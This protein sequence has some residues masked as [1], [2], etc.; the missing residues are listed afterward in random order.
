MALQED[1]DAVVRL[2][3]KDVGSPSKEI[4]AVWGK[5]LIS[6]S[7][8]PYNT[9]TIWGSAS[10]QWF[11]TLDAIWNGTSQSFGGFDAP[12]FSLPAPAPNSQAAQQQT[13][14]A[15]REAN[16]ALVSGRVIIVGEP[17]ADYNGRL[18]I[19]GARNGIDGR[20]RIDN[21]E[22]SYNRRSGYLTTIDL[23]GVA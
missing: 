19:V 11:S 13:E 2:S 12:A 22:H 4:S 17:A 21:C 8:E 6:W 14:G 5:N 3:A 23:L 10:Q 16:T 20:Y 15:Q 7:V 9:R 18:T 1:F